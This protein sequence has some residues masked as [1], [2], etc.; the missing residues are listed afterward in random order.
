MYYN[1][2]GK[3]SPDKK[4][5]FVLT[6]KNQTTPGL[7]PFTSSSYGIWFLLWTTG[8]RWLIQGFLG[9]NASLVMVSSL[10]LEVSLH[11][12]S[13]CRFD[14]LLSPMIYNCSIAWLNWN[15]PS[16]VLWRIWLCSGRQPANKISREINIQSQL[17]QGKT[18]PC[19]E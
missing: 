6:E 14:I 12:A 16:L 11:N 2:L 5:L 7:H 8:T 17:L 15:P 3:V 19:L 9:A 1:I 10:N 4:T 13:Q 18:T